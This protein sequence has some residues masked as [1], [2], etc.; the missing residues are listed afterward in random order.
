MVAVKEGKACLGASDCQPG[1]GQCPTTS[2]T[3]TTTPNTITTTTI[4]PQVNGSVSLQ[5]DDH[6]SE[7]KADG[8]LPPSDRTNTDGV[9]GSSLVDGVDG[10]GEDGGGDDTNELLAAAR[11]KKNGAAAVGAIVV[12]VVVL[13]AMAVMVWWVKRR[14]RGGDE[15]GEGATVLNA[16]YN[17]PSFDTQSVV[18]ARRPQQR[19]PP[20]DVE[21]GVLYLEPVA[22]AQQLNVYDDA[23]DGGSG[24][25][26][27]GGGGAGNKRVSYLAPS[28]D[29]PA[30]YDDA[31]AVDGG[32]G[33]AG[34]ERVSYL[35]PSEDQP[36]I[37]D[38]ARAAG[39]P[40]SANYDGFGINAPDGGGGGSNVYLAPSTLRRQSCDGPAE[41]AQYAEAT[42]AFDPLYAEAD[43][44]WGQPATAIVNG[45]GEVVYAVPMM[46]GATASP[47]GDTSS[48]YEYAG[49][50]MHM[51]TVSHAY[52]VDT[53]EYVEA[54]VQLG[55]SV[56]DTALEH[57]DDD[58]FC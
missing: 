24:G 41:S 12:I 25:G 50:E 55:V 18:P 16:T 26:G 47:N 36:A 31:R 57:A 33:V 35:A 27:G 54:N 2:S 51:A 28:E 45:P 7:G 52:G 8:K 46:A 21:A 14:N 30:I 34:N 3:A 19:L 32:G 17:N 38:D 5:H 39:L 56:Y 29:Q 53:A 49:L 37:Y 20:V 40:S 48:N 23:T 58:G 10:A 4:T 9:E 1:D 6:T 44:N 42:D 11:K 15:V 13:V 43:D 22:L